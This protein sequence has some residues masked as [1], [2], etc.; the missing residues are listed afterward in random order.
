MGDR[1]KAIKDLVDQIESSWAERLL[2]RRLSDIHHPLP[3]VSRPSSDLASLSSTVNEDSHNRK[4]VSPTYHQENSHLDTNKSFETPNSANKGNQESEASSRCEPDSSTDIE[5]SF[6]ARPTIDMQSGANWRLKPQLRARS[7][8]NSSQTKSRRA[9]PSSNQF[10]TRNVEENLVKSTLSPNSSKER[11][12]ALSRLTEMETTENEKK[13][14]YSK[15][16]HLPDLRNSDSSSKEIN[17]DKVD[18]KQPTR[19]KSFDQE[20]PNLAKSRGYKIPE[21]LSERQLNGHKALQ[22]RLGYDP[23]ASVA[24]EKFKSKVMDNS[25]HRIAPKEH[26]NHLTNARNES[27]EF[28][29]N[30]STKRL[31]SIDSKSVQSRTSK[32]NSTAFNGSSKSQSLCRQEDML[33]V[34]RY[35]HSDVVHISKLGTRVIQGPQLMTDRCNT[36]S[37]GAGDKDTRKRNTTNVPFGR[38]Q[39]EHRETK[40]KSIQTVNDNSND[41]DCVVEVISQKLERLA[42]HVVRLRKLV[43][44]D[45]SETGYCS[46]GDDIYGDEEVGAMSKGKPTGMHPYIASSLRNIRL[47]EANIQEIFDLLYANEAQIW[48]PV[49]LQDQFSVREAPQLQDGRQWVISSLSGSGFIGHCRMPKSVTESDNDAN[50]C[51]LIA[52]VS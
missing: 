22:R 29:K 31:P 20:C 21:G 49:G 41:S 6:Y 12:S 16:S 52:F 13:A 45:Y 9:P 46:A 10:V 35:S 42:T 38:T 32:Q 3:Q 50:Q 43:E 34:R 18:R 19:G 33:I 40:P 44:R 1:S 28:T 48:C 36:R 8:L 4:V 37:V 7:G 24:K 15:L 26:E 14:L 5:P 47:L 11:V 23:Q 39:S 27:T 30:R 51:T 25:D 17:G 2:R